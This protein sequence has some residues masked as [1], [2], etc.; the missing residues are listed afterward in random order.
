MKRLPEVKSVTN[1]VQL[2]FAVTFLVLIAVLAVFMN[3]YPTIAARDLVFS[4]KKASLQNQAGVMSSALS[5]PEELTSD[6]VP[7]V[8]DQLDLR[9]LTRVIVTD[10][11]AR[12]LYDNAQFD[13]S[14]GRYAM[15]SEIAR[16]LSD[17]IVC[18]SVYDGRAFMTREA[19]PIRSGGTTVGAVYLYEYDA[20]QAEL[21]ASIQNR[22]RSV[23]MLVSAAAIVLMFIFS[24]ALT[25]RIT[26]LAK[27]TRIVSEG[28]YDHRI[29]VSGH[30]ELSELGMEFNSLTARLK[31]TEEL[32]RRF[33]SDASHELKTPLASIRLLSDSIVNSEDMDVD[34]MRDFV[35][36][37]ESEA[38]RLQ[39]TTEKLLSLSRIDSGTS[40]TRERVDLRQV[41]EKTLRLL[42]PL[43]K[44]N[45]VAITTELQKGCFVW[46]NE[47]LLYRVI[48]NLAENAVKYN[49]PGGTVNILLRSEGEEV[50]LTVA[51][52][53]IGIPDEDL[54]HIFTRF[55]R[56]D[57]ARST[58]AGGSGL[59]LSI[60]HDAVKLHGGDITVEKQ[61]EGGTRF[62]VR[63]PACPEN[64]P[65][66][67]ADKT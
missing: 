5:A 4:S 22:L 2:K 59:G 27:A 36:D 25:L 43:A 9:S 24:R 13:P 47:D 18:Y 29:P 28:D 6:T 12:V 37:I 64:V 1:S 3:T 8:M 14:V 58:D 35:N 19:M 39:R 53:G 50:V 52:T 42:H 63:L 55:Y 16:A 67:G 65:E 20:S 49:M 21:I 51:D 62:I 44:E 34:T 17:E 10:E 11:D 56:V 40:L 7:A 26:E 60:A 46:G 54:P 31:E 33:V 61:S 15:L 32:R 23:S 38:E 30:D 41:V 66:E 45:Q 48:F 57:K